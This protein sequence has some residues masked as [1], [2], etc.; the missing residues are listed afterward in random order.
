MNRTALDIGVLEINYSLG[1]GAWYLV[2]GA[3]DL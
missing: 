3:W 2:L 1:F